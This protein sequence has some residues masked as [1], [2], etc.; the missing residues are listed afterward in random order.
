MLANPLITIPINVIGAI[1]GANVAVALG[2][3]QWFPL[4]AVWGWPL[5]Q[6]FPAYAAGMIAGVLVVAFGNI[7]VRYYLIKKNPNGDL[8]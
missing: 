1:V 3:V 4:P 7:F 6:N 5:V 8:E 2:A